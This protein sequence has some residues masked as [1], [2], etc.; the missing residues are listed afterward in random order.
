MLARAAAWDSIPAEAAAEAF[1]E[2]ARR[3]AD[4][5]DDL[6]TALMRK[7]RRNIDLLPEG[8]DPTV[9][10]SQALT[11]ARGSHNFATDLMKP[12]DTVKEE[13]TKAIGDL[14]AKLAGDD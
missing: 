12:E 10:F 7:L 8:Q 14:I 9:R 3:I 1:A 5:H 4:Q 2:R 11:A 13:I 6:A